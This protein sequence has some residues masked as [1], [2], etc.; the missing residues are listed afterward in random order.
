MNVSL[1]SFSARPA[2][3][4][5][6][7]RWLYGFLLLFLIGKC[8]TFHHGFFWD[9]TA[10]YAMPAD[11]LRTHGFLSFIYPAHYVAEPPLA[12]LYLAGL[13]TVLG[14]S[15]LV[16]HLSVTLFSLGVFW[17][18]YRLCEET[19]PRYAPWLFLTLALEPALLTQSVLLSP[20]IL[21]C[22][23]ALSSIRFLLA[24]RRA[25]LALSALCLG[26]ISLRGFVVCAGLGLG[27]LLIQLLIRRKSF[28]A[29][30]AYALPPFLPVLFALGSWFVY[31][32]IETGYWLYAP[33]FAYREHREWADAG[34]GIKNLLGFGFRMVDSGRII[35]WLFFLA[36][37]FKMGLKAAVAFLCRSSLALLYLS[38]LFVLLWVTLP[39]TNPFGDRYFLVLFILLALVTAQLLLQTYTPKQVRVFFICMILVL[40]SGHAWVYPEKIAKAWDSVLSHVPYYALR[41]QMIRYLE[42]ERIAP[43]E[44]AASFPLNAAFGDTQV[45]DDAR[46]FA[47]LDWEHSRYILYSNV[48]NWDDESLAKIHS[49]NWVLLKEF[50]S[51]FV[52]MRL[53]RAAHP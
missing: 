44:V 1:N 24:D 52:C 46:S 10:G 48:Y 22:F 6:S 18:L 4:A 53:Y 32:K 43:A 5:V 51:G 49:A 29:A 50:K 41:N 2:N 20:D 47:A 38:V 25:Y 31:R 34:Q 17:Q 23:F 14:R 39:V 37:V 7:R 9:H 11:Y 16:A 35:V 15:L 33:D 26:L 13:W 21:L 40:A 8:F 36:A 42:T 27:Y 45:T 12:H 28:R 3:K 19:A 30:L